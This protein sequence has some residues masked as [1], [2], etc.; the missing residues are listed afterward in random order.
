MGFKDGSADAIFLKAIA[1]ISSINSKIE[2]FEDPTFKNLSFNSKQFERSNSEKESFE[3][4]SL[5]TPKVL[6]HNSNTNNQL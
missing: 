1:L 5:K 3:S 4:K 2:N 6:F